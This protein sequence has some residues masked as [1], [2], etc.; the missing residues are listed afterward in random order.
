MTMRAMVWAQAACLAIALVS[1]AAAAE[2]TRFGLSTGVEYTSG[3]FGGSEDIEDLYVPIAASADVGR[4]NFRLTVPYVSVRAPSETTE[5]GEDGQPIAGTGN[6]S[7]ESGLG[8]IV[9]SVTIYDVVNKPGLGFALD[10]T[11]TVKFGTADLDK[12]L[13]TGE[14]DYSVRV[15]AYKFYDRVILMGSAGYK[16]RGEP[17][18]VEFDDVWLGSVGGAYEVSTHTLM[19]LYYD[20]RQSPLATGDDIQELTGFV[21]TRLSDGWNIEIYTFAGFSHSSPDWGAGL[22]LSTDFRGVRAPG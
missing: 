12:G 2:D 19:G 6:T 17:E 21:S 1:N 9:G 4:L 15:D 5:S 20:H 18:G 11:G 16:F 22:I 10:V 7:T 14:N 8:D 13:G 3:D